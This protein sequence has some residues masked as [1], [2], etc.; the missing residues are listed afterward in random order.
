MSSLGQGGLGPP[1]VLVVAIGNPDR[2]DDGVGALVATRLAGRLPSDVKLMSRHGD[3]ISLI[4][5]WAGFDVVI[6]IDAAE[7]SGTPGRIDRF[8]A[9][10]LPRGASFASSHAF[11]LAETIALAGALRSRPKTLI[12]YAI[13]GG[14][15]DHGAAL[16]PQVVAAAAEVADR[17]VAEVSR[18][19]AFAARPLVEQKG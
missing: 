9:G 19:G 5:D 7:P 10:G 8:H 1:K 6:C 3:I 13:E 11:G 15:F 2:G 12:V 17:V 16:T 14:C 18:Q 4:E